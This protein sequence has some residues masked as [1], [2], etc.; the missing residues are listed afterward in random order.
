MADKVLCPARVPSTL[1]VSRPQADQL[2][3]LLKKAKTTLN[4]KKTSDPDADLLENALTFISDNTE[5]PGSSWINRPR[6]IAVVCTGSQEQPEPQSGA[7]RESYF[8]TLHHMLSYRD[9]RRQ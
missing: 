3:G 4:S 8:R 1:I 2:L 7:R 9:L 5:D 6:L